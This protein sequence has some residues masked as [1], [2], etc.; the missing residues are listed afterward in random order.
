MRAMTERK[1]GDRHRDDEMK[2]PS[3]LSLNLTHVDPIAREINGHSQCI[4][5]HVTGIPVINQEVTTMKSICSR[6]R[7]ESFIFILG[8]LFLSTL[9]TLLILFTGHKEGDI[10]NN[11]NVSISTRKSSPSNLDPDSYV[12]GDDLQ[13][14]DGERDHNPLE[15]IKRKSGQGGSRG[16]TAT[17]PYNFTALVWCNE[18]T[19]NLTDDNST[20]CVHPIK[21]TWKSFVW[22]FV[23]VILPI[24]IISYCKCRCCRERVQ[25]FKRNHLSSLNCDLCNRELK[26][27]STHIDPN[28]NYPV[29]PGSSLFAPRAPIVPAGSVPQMVS[30][31]VAVYTI[32]RWVKWPKN[33]I[34]RTWIDGCSCCPNHIIT[35][36]WSHLLGEWTFSQ[37]PSS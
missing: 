18:T 5:R 27:S 21:L 3:W 34:T 22:V 30:P 35:A 29:Q 20:D 1:W 19:F 8:I 9:V 16:S 11:L 12:P 7:L 15:R 32:Y 33:W 25:N 10:S 31:G 28:G 6:I 23:F 26:T 37:S 36:S 4:S 14:N 17:T 2:S 24:C 13:D